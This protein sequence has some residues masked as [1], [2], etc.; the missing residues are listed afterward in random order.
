MTY[1][2]EILAALWALAYVFASRWLPSAFGRSIVGG[3]EFWRGV[4]ALPSQFVLFPAALAFRGAVADW[5]FTYVFALYMLLDLVLAGHMDSI[6]YAHHGVC[7]L[8]HAIVVF[9]LP[10]EAFRTYFAGVVALELGSGVMNVWALTGARWANGLYAAGMSA[11]NAAA[12]YL[13][14]RWSQLPIALAPKVVCLIVAASLIVLRQQACHEN[15]RIGMPRHLLRS[16]QD[17]WSKI[18]LTPK[19]LTATFFTT[20][21]P[22]VFFEFFSQ[23]SG[24]RLARF[25]PPLRLAL[26]GRG[27]R[28]L[29]RL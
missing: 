5:L 20:V 4:W 12:A 21:V 13:T 11:S 23:N 6:Y 22:L 8:G 18:Y 27:W 25:G 10:E 26:A 14:W 2:A 1:L 17:R 9:T 19:Y 7:V 29:L 15:V 28:R 24:K 3:M 16:V